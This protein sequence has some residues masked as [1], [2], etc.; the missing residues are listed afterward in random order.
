MI[1]VR[2]SGDRG[3]NQFD[4]LDSRHTFSFGEYHDPQHMAY[5][6]LR[7]I[8][9][10]HVAAGGGFGMHPHRDME[11]VTYVISGVLEH[12]DSMGNGSLIQP[13][14]F[15]RMTAGSGVAHSEF[16]HSKTSSVHLLQI[17]LLPERRGLEPGYE[18][19]TFS[20]AARQGKLCLVASPDAREGSLK[21]HQDAEL[22]VSTL[23]T[24][25][26]V[27]HVFRPRRFGWLQ[28]FRGEV[29]VNGTRLAE[30]DGASIG[31][32]KS[33]RIVG[34]TDGRAAEFLLFDLA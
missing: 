12:K 7:V 29:E 4:W 9:E 13:G 32:E 2:K 3:H 31:D 16:N 26:A 17:W 34:K 27:E 6:A 28:V 23:K 15:Q 19:K 18:Q 11:I 20:P 33:L 25:D 8:N 10:D 5:R 21:I 30:G 22:F 1:E 14:E 24:D